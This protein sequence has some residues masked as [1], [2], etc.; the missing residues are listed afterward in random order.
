MSTSTHPATGG[1]LVQ[2]SSLEELVR[3]RVAE[4]RARLEKEAGIRMPVFHAV[5]KYDGGSSDDVAYLAPI[6]H[7]ARRLDG[8][9]QYSIRGSPYFHTFPLCRPDDRLAIL[10]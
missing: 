8:G 9:A 3:Q 2:I 10:E 7:A 6:D 5:R 1:G 4:E